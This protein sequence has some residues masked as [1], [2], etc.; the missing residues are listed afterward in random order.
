M[1]THM[2]DRYKDLITGGTLVAALALFSGI[3]GWDGMVSSFLLLFGVL[4]HSQLLG[5][6]LFPKHAWPAS[7]GFGLVLYLALQTFFQTL[8]FYADARLGFSSDIWTACLGMASVLALYVLIP[9]NEQERSPFEIRSD[10]WILKSLLL[11]T[12]CAFLVFVLTVAMRVSTGASIRTPWP[13]LPPGTLLALG[14][15][16]IVP[17]VAT[18]RLRSAGFTALL[19]ALAF[20]ATTSLP[21]I[22]YRLG[23][24]FDGFLHVASEK[25]ILQSGTLQP[26]PFYYIGQYVF[27]T[28][29]S[30]L[31]EIPIG[32]IDRWLVPVSAAIL[33][34]YAV[35]LATSPRHPSR[36]ASLFVISLVPFIA[37]TPQSFAYTLGLTAILLTLGW[38]HRTVH[39]LA[40]LLLCA[41]TTLVHPLAGVPFTVLVLALLLANVSDVSRLRRVRIGASLF[42]AV[43][44]AFVVPALFY[45][46]SGREGTNIEWDI[47]ALVSSKPWIQL[48]ETISPFLKNYFVVWPAWST[49]V[50]QSTFVVFAIATLVLLRKGTRAEKQLA[51]VSLL[52][53]VCLEISSAVLKTAGDFTFLIDYERGN[54]AER[55]AVL[56]LLVLVPATL[57]TVSR[58]MERVRLTR[59]AFFASFLLLAFSVSSAHAYAA[60]PRNDALV[61]GRGWSVGESDVAAVRFIDRDAGDRK[62]AVLAN[63]SVS[64]AAVSQF[65]FKRYAG[66]V[67]YYPIPTGGPLYELFL[68]FVYNEPDLDVIHEAAKLS[69]SEIIYV[70]LNDYWWNAE[71]VAESITPLADEEWE[72]GNASKGLGNEVKV[73]KFEIK[74]KK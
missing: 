13:L 33:L 19:T 32:D 20:F 22:L 21:A 47:S 68:K 57:T 51:S 18:W 37:T 52:S 28:W 42:F 1:S 64:A 34:P 15:L 40:P 67:F 14:A 31:T 9:T 74:E 69:D 35:Y 2:E 49:L 59:P 53:A 25:L 30:R 56:A 72:F 48:L 29:L 16:W 63:Q 55:L 12:S 66:D 7:M 6:T 71:R 10:G 58:F 54:Y 44:S 3:F 4:F 17:I 73:Y 45:L 11:I 50:E 61:V 27:T 43:A 39:P 36:I 8:L 46:M 5:K 62:Y 70:V 23:Y 41:W 24:G 38:E 60:L 26:K 65:G